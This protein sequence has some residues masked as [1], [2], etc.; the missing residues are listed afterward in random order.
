M[1]IKVADG[2][3]GSVP[4]NISVLDD[5]TVEASLITGGGCF[6]AL[7][8]PR[9]EFSVRSPSGETLEADEGGVFQM[10]G[11][12]LRSS[13]CQRCGGGERTLSDRDGNVLFSAK[14]FLGAMCAGTTVTVLDGIRAVKT[15]I[16]YS[17]SGKD[18]FTDITI[19]LPDGTSV[20]KRGVRPAITE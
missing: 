1:T 15:D 12:Y 2:N 4:V 14:S 16:K 10:P 17:I 6:T 13:D 5:G 20:E 19:T 18:A 7:S 9:G 11:F 3:L 8:S